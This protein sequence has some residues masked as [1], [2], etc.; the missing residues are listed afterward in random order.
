MIPAITKGKKVYGLL[1]Y[2]FG[3]GRREEHTN[4][5]LVAVWNG[6]G[7]VAELEPPIH[8][9]GSRD[10]RRLADLLNQ[11]VLAAMRKPNKPVWHCSIR[12]HPSDRVLSDQQWA[13]IAGEVMA[14]VGLAPHGD[15][16]AVRWVAV[17]H[18]EDH[19]HLVATLVRQDRRRAWTNYDYRK[20]QQ[21]CRD[22]EERYNLYRVAPPGQG[23]RRWPSPDELNK[24]TRL[25][26]ASTSRP[27]TSRPATG[28]RATSRSRRGPV[29]PRERLRRLVRAAAATATDEDDF[30]AKLDRAGVKV[31]LR[32]S[33]RNPEQV[34]GYAVG[35]DGHAN[36]DGET[37]FYGGGKL[38]ADL[39]LPK[40]R[41]RWTGAPPEDP[42]PPMTEAQRVAALSF[43]PTGVYARAERVT[44]QA[45]Q[46][47]RTTGDPAQAAGIARAAADVLTAIA[48]RWEGRDGGPLTEAAELFDRAAHDQRV[49]AA[50]DN[51]HATRMRG[52]ARLIL[53][54]AAVSRDEDVSNTTRLLLTLALFLTAWAEMREARRLVHQAHAAREAAARLRSWTPPPGAA[55]ATGPAAPGPDLFRTARPVATPCHRR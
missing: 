44:R 39:S 53:V 52:V 17:R 29:A 38:A 2:L 36:P 45:A 21:A 46:A 43:P 11:P 20:A 37:I 4:A 12:T 49:T 33:S 10:V 13:H 54:A 8:G 9:D 18:A 23:S 41:R 51:L 48:Q 6:A 55:T 14:A 25:H 35:L 47:L 30:F 5:H 27:A 50:H 42:A 3:P 22:L 28:P 31:K 15:Q 32:H 24:T 7:P 34:T 40:L 26:Q 19:I 16:Q 1:R